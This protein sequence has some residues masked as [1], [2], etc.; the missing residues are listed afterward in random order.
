MSNQSNTNINTLE[1]N[2]KL[3]NENLNEMLNKNEANKMKK[4]INHIFEIIIK[5]EI[6]D[7]SKKSYSYLND[8]INILE[9]FLT[10]RNLETSLIII[11]EIY[12]LLSNIKSQEILTYLFSIQ[13]KDYNEFGINF[14]IF[15]YLISINSFEKNEEFL[16]HQ[17]NLMKS[18]ILKLDSESIKYFYKSDINCFKIL[19]RSLFLYDYPEQM[20]RS[21]ISNI[22]LLIT[23]NKNKALNE[24]LSS[25]PVALYYVIIIY[26]LKKIIL[27]LNTEFIK[28]KNV[29]EYFEEKHEE[30]YETVLYINDILLCNIKN[31]NFIL[32]NC[33]LNEI[34]FPLFNVIISQTKENISVINAIYALSFLIYYIK[35]DFIINVISYFLFSE[36]IPSVFFEKMKKYKYI[37]INSQLIEDINFLIKNVDIADINDDYWKRNAEFIKQDIGMDLYTGNICNDNNYDFFKNMMINVKNNKCNDIDFNINEIFICICELMTSQDENIILNMCILFYNIIYHFMNYFKTENNENKGN[38]NEDEI[39]QKNKIKIS[40]V[41]TNNLNN[42]NNKCNPKYQYKI[43]VYI[44]NTKSLFNPVLLSFFNFT[45]INNN[46]NFTNL[47]KI[48]LNL[49]KRRNKFRIFTNELIINILSLLIQIF[50]LEQNYISREVYNLIKEIKSVLKE[51]INNIKSILN[52]E[53]E[54]F[55]FYNIKSIYNYLNNQKFN[56][57]LLDM[58]NSYYIL[59]IPFMHSEKNDK[60]PFSLI[61]D[62]S[63][64]NIIKNNMLNILLLL[65]IIQKINKSNKIDITFKL[66]E[67]EKENINNFEIGKL[68]NKNNIGKEYGFCFIGYNY[69]DFKFNVQ[70]IKKCLFIFSNL[71]FNLGEIISKTFKNISDI[72]ILNTIPIMA[73]NIKISLTEKNYLEIKDIRNSNKIIMNCFTENNTQKVYNYFS[74]MINNDN[75]IKK[76]DFNLFFKNIENIILK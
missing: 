14:N 73:L 2:L 56:S 54:K 3:S 33:I 10:K 42:I 58:M 76:R 60:I 34:I 6:S 44:N 40:K 65:D 16:N 62:N 11:K 55:N 71:Y 12:F 47:L 43:N 70:S 39:I 49:I 37:P 31:I 4:E 17:V 15:D 63:N 18:L 74:F 26:N 1:Q 52:N 64:D 51:D 24:Y 20:L 41:E 59:T 38:L 75:D 30:L 57:K 67:K 21:V 66:F 72:K 69:D 19:N 32:I 36:K 53:S 46:I 5:T 50:C 25:F 13:N 29:F 23:K 45:I 7:F 35:N 48:T 9:K 61:E 68:Y 22:I 8:L 28:G 27:E